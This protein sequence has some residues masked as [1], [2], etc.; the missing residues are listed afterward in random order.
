MQRSICSSLTRPLLPLPV[1]LLGLVLAPA[2]AR[3]QVEEFVVDAGEDVVLQC[4]SAAGTSYT[5]NG[6]VPEGPDV[7]F[8]WSTMPPVTLEDD[9]TLT[10]TGEFPIGETVVTLDAT[11]PVAMLSGSDSVS[12]TVEDTE[13]PVVQVLAD[14][15]V[16]WPPNHELRR[17]NVRV[18]TRDGCSSQE[19]LTVELVSVESNEPDNGQGDGNTTNDIQDAQLGSDDTQVLLRAERSGRGHGRVYTLVYRVS[20]GAGNQTEA[21]AKVYVPHDYSDVR[22]RIMD[23]MNG[24]REDMENI[25]PRPD[26]AT[27]EFIDALPDLSTFA[28]RGS[29]ID[30]CRTWNRGCNGI[31]G[32]SARCVYSEIRALQ[33]LDGEDCD[34]IEDRHERRSCRRAQKSDTSGSLDE[35]RQQYREA[36]ATCESVGR[37]CANACNTLFDPNGSAFD[38]EGVN[39]P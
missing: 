27:E 35:L 34:A 17:V 23:E 15:S 36:N 1:I 19:D 22:N 2:S 33:R 18:R 37:R 16:L 9:D 26:V 13:P 12:V 29:C 14:P 3:A 8:S 21:E 6:S 11:D 10:P 24:D 28:D 20:D 31:S 38:N 4:E 7:T 39:E 30:A 32:G 25:C 5:L